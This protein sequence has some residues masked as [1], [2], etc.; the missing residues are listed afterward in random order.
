MNIYDVTLYEQSIL[1]IE[2]NHCF[3]ISITPVIFPVFPKCCW[4]VLSMLRWNHLW[5]IHIGIHIKV[6]HASIKGNVLFGLGCF[7]GKAGSFQTKLVS[8]IIEHSCLKSFSYQISN[9]SRDTFYLFCCLYIILDHCR[10]SENN[11]SASGTK[12]CICV[13]PQLFSAVCTIQPNESSNPRIH[14]Y[15]SPWNLMDREK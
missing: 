15:N 12:I 3:W 1:K 4:Y 10:I 6:R 9:N 13:G 5:V 8:K 7:P 11:C 2:K 14:E